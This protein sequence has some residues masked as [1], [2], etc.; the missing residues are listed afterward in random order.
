MHRAPENGG[1]MYVP[2]PDLIPLLEAHL[3]GG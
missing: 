1:L 2:P 3:G